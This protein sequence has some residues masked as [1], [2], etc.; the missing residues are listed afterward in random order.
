LS[1]LIIAFRPE[2]KKY[3]S[4]D[5]KLLVQLLKALYGCIEAGNLWF[6]MLQDVILALRIEY[7]GVTTSFI[8]NPSGEC[9][10]NV[11]RNGIQCTLCVFVDD[12]AVDSECSVLLGIVQS[13]LE[14]HFPGTT[15]HVGYIHNYLGMTF[16]LLADAVSVKMPKITE[17]LIAEYPVEKTF[18]TPSASDLFKIDADSPLLEESERKA[19]HSAVMKV[20]WMAERARPDLALVTSFLATRTRIFTQQDVVKFRHMMGYLKLTRHL[21][22]LLRINPSTGPQV[23]TMVDIAHAVHAD[24]KDQVGHIISLGTGAVQAKSKKSRVVTRSSTEGEIHG[25]SEV[26]SPTIGLRNF[27]L[28]QGYSA[29]GPAIIREDN[30]PSIH[31]IDR[32]RPGNDAARHICIRVFQAHHFQKDGQIILKWIATAEQAADSLTKPTQGATFESHRD[33]GILS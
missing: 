4:R 11:Y 10:Y 2:W 25:I 6:L 12:I 30:Q 23:I 21:G 15:T 31:M 16:E 33:N 26:I 17:D 8:E 7:N 22:L 28:G 24:Y 13:H 20:K 1:A 29:I 3:L 19:L 27:M 9:V 5:G 14:S 32:G 18:K